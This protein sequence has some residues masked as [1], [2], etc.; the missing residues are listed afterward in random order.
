M[1]WTPLATI[2]VE[3]WFDKQ[4]RTAAGKLNEAIQTLVADRAQLDETVARLKGEDPATVDATNIV[5][6]GAFRLTRFEIL[7]GEV[8]VRRELTAF[9]S[10]FFQALPAAARKAAETHREV[11][12]SLTEAMQAIG[13]IMKGPDRLR[14]A[15]GV[16]SSHPGVR[17][18]RDYAERLSNA[19]NDHSRERQNAE[20]VDAITLELSTAV[21][22]GLSAV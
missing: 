20:A 16:I 12:R 13:F 11:E 9:W 19:M 18:A 17:A 1:S 4:L 7:Q 10:E 3:T 22:G 15:P 14:W 8:R 5:D 6:F 2:A 21:A